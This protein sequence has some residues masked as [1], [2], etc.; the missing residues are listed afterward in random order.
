[1]CAYGMP[2]GEPPIAVEGGGGQSFEVA[3]RQVAQSNNP[4][5]K[6]EAGEGE[7]LSKV[8]QDTESTETL[9]E[10]VIR[11]NSRNQ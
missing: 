4:R 6:R 8:L 7:V 5:A 3:F 11:V 1:I 10:L 9:Q 2:A